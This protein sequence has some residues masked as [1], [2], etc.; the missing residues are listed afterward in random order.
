MAIKDELKDLDVARKKIDVFDVQVKA[1]ESAQAEQAR[2]QRA[3]NK[4]LEAS[5]SKRP[6]AVFS[7]KTNLEKK[8]FQQIK[9]EGRR[10]VRVAIK[11][12]KEELVK[13]GA[14][15]EDIKEV[16]EKGK[17]FPVGLEAIS[18]KAI[19]KKV[20]L[21]KRKQIGLIPDVNVS[22][23]EIPRIKL[24]KDISKIKR[25]F[26]V[27]EISLIPGIRR[28]AEK[29][30]NIVTI[31]ESA[32]IE[33]KVISI[34]LP[35]T[36]KGTQITRPVD[37]T[38]IDTGR[39][40]NRQNFDL[41]TNKILTDFNT[42]RLNEKRALSDLETAQKKFV[43]NEAKR[44]APLRFI[45]GAGIGA[46]TV[47]APPLG[48]SVIGLGTVDALAKRKEILEFSKRNPGAA[49]IQFTSG[50]VGGFVG[51]GGVK[52]AIIKKATIKEPTIKLTGKA[53]TRLRDQIIENLDTDTRIKFEIPIKTTG[54]RA[55]EINIPS[56]KNNVVLRIMEFS[57][58]GVRNFAGLEIIKGKVKS[59]IR[60][61]TLGKG[62]TG[63]AD[64]ITR[65]IRQNT[66]RGLTNLELSQFLEKTKLVGSRNIQNRVVSLT[67]SETKLAKQFG[68]KKLNA[69]QVR[70]IL[71]RP[72]FG[73]KESQKRINKPFTDIEFKLAS[74]VGKSQ[75]QISEK[76]VT[77]RINRLTKQV[78]N[79]IS[80]R[81]FLDIRVIETG[82]G[83]INL[84]FTL[85]KPKVG[86]IKVK[87]K[88]RPIN[89]IDTSRITIKK[90]K[91][92][93]KT[94]LS[95]TFSQQTEQI[96]KS[97]VPKSIKLKKLRNLQKKVSPT[98]TFR[99][100]A[101]V[102]QKERIRIATKQA[103][104]I[105]AITAFGTEVSLVSKSKTI[106][107]I[108]SLSKTKPAIGLATVNK[109]LV[110]Q[111][112]VLALGGKIT[113]VQ[114]QSLKQKLILKQSRIPTKKQK[115]ITKPVVPIVPIIP[116]GVKQTDLIMAIQ[117]LGKKN[118][119]D[120]LVGMKTGKRKS[121]G[122]SLPPYKAL[123]KA[124]KFVDKNIE[125]S[126]LLK[127]TKKIPKQKDIK[128]FNLQKKFQPSKVNPFFK[129]EK[130]RFRLD[131]PTEVRQ[132]KA[133]KGKVSKSFFGKPKKGKK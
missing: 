88:K 99:A 11:R 86:K 73:I 126:F 124:Q 81:N 87:G 90:T 22:R 27:P 14:K 60:G 61:I 68:L 107:K 110:A 96:L 21:P 98:G 7:L 48:W 33:Q 100:I 78:K 103:A 12:G 83:V 26:N 72:L 76:L 56:P 19:V 114:L 80:E 120:I 95:K 4:A 3:F 1:A 58:D 74:K 132:L 24:K 55:F 79:L 109:P 47:L 91:L 116:K 49:A 63:S 59:T 37:F 35:S 111:A 69:G 127:P 85:P 17:L 125:A 20:T 43:F 70:E 71:R 57:K 30:I 92:P 129:V 8:F 101:K 93:K 34:N 97:K 23:V 131:S 46:L 113:Q 118:A 32:S 2:Q 130:K 84:E 38:D 18:S 52:A 108:K 44:T 102:I 128:P 13:Q 39:L 45:E 115:V 133:F 25:T 89:I 15:L 6:E 119:V 65:V 122:K 106:Q 31:P 64:L 9:A 29:A 123:K 5:L 82:K 54:T 112:E 75:M 121:I 10:Q 104:G 42:G 94:L 62:K 105:S 53:R 36:I 51:A 77:I 117:K 50:V 16:F 67:E 66:K 40:P 41:K 28:V